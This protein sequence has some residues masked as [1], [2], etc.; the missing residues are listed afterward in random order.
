M[1]ANPKGS[2]NKY[3]TTLIFDTESE[4]KRF[5]QLGS[6]LSQERGLSISRCVLIALE[7]ANKNIRSDNLRI[8]AL[9]NRMTKLET[10]LDAVKLQ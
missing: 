6:S 7:D 10:M 8:N 9:E 5:K 3:R 1:G 2:N 4:L